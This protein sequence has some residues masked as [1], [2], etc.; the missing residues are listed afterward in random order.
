MDGWQTVFLPL[1]DTCVT[2]YNATI[3]NWEGVVDKNVLS[4]ENLHKF[5]MVILR[6]SDL[7]VISISIHK[8]APGFADLAAKRAIL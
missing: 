3:V 8:A 7:A 5:S 4:L 2:T 6:K 1:S